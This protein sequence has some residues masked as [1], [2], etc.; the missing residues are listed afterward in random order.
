M[1]IR[2]NALRILFVL[3][4]CLFFSNAL[5]QNDCAGELNKI[6]AKTDVAIAPCAEYFFD[7]ESTA[8]AQN[9]AQGLEG[10]FERAEFFPNHGFTKGRYWFRLRLKAESEKGT[11]VVLSLGNALAR[12][13]TAY[14]ILP[15]GQLREIAT[16]IQ[17]N[18]NKDDR[19]RTSDVAL[20]LTLQDSNEKE[21]LVEANSVAQSIRPYLRGIAA[22]ENQISK[23]L[24]LFGMYCGIIFIMV[25][26]N[27][28]IYFGVKGKSYLFYAGTILFLH[29]LSFTTLIG[30]T[31]LLL[32]D[33]PALAMRHLH[34]SLALG[35]VF[36]IFFSISFLN[37]NASHPRA[38]IIAKSV[39]VLL[40]LQIIQV[41]FDVQ[42]STAAF[43]TAH[44]ILLLSV[45]FY[46][47]IDKALRKERPA[48]IFLIA[49]SA[50]SLGWLA[51]NGA[52]FGFFQHSTLT[53]GGMIVG[54]VFEI[55]LFSIA[56]A[57]K[58]NNLRSEKEGALKRE[59]ESAAH[60]AQME[61]E[62][63]A[64]RAVQETLLPEVHTFHSAYFEFES[65][66]HSCNEVGGDWFWYSTDE[67]T[68]DIF[69]YVGDVNG[70]GIPSALMTGVV[71]GSISSLET[72]MVTHNSEHHLENT[73]AILNE[74][75]LKTGT[76]GKRL[77]T[78]SLICIN[79]N[80][81]I[82]SY[83]NAGHPFPMIWNNVT[84]S[85]ISL[86]GTNPSFGT[87]Q[88]TFKAHNVKLQ[89]GDILFMYTDGFR[90]AQDLIK[91]DKNTPRK[92]EMLE[93]FSGLDTAQALKERIKER[94]DP[95]FEGKEKVKDD[96]TY[97]L[98]RWIQRRVTRKVG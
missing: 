9:I 13:A 1:G 30:G 75:I 53:Q 12:S 62:L 61:A 3:L 4:V 65:Y 38:S 63:Q 59:A 92:K 23:E 78:M 73:A 40:P 50:L 29:G 89:P 33:S 7:P 57:D 18:E 28:W 5:A 95:A 67:T 16:T 86:T 97:V 42:S 76:R 22:H 6:N 72:E 37:A 90:E 82:L 94:L 10:K 19:I 20:K 69:I 52:Q 15:N 36:A 48:R 68:G 27:L 55:I 84:Q 45:V 25:L 17:K 8:T 31:K 46:I 34:F 60:K 41:F 79:P 49:W 71:C 54:S 77:V 43:R 39:L 91:S 51:F 81:G 88:A 58:I 21:F 24:L 11:D 87:P 64:A 44:L 26:Y 56:L 32:P 83:I 80:T 74:V 35:F 70:H 14:L 98:V 96:V 47:A 93:L 85:F 2:V 66:Y